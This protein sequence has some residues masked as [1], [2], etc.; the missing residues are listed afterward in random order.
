MGPEVMN[1]LV[2]KCIVT[3]AALA[4]LGARLAMAAPAAPLK[5]PEFDA[6]A[7]KASESVNV[8]LDASLLGLAASFLD[9]SDPQDAG[10]K[11]LI[12]GLRGIYVRSYTF[13]R[14]VP[15]PAAEIDSLHRQLSTPGWQSLVKVRKEKEHT[16][17]DIYISTDQGK[18]NGLA[19]IV[20]EPR[21][22]TVVNIVGSI[23]LEK[24][25]RLEGKFGVP[26]MPLPEG[27]PSAAA[28]AP[29]PAPMPLPARP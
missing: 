3:L 17:V 11:Q 16:N 1:S 9:P 2:R 28:P 13:D 20:S 25:R 22:F 23:D 18:A 15:Y 14:D 10:A 21:E 4:V 6:L 5:L 24:L 26:K 29:S 7:A 27:D 12:A 19:I 8:S